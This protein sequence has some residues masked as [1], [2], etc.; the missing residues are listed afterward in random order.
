MLVLCIFRIL[1]SIMHYL[2]Q[3]NFMCMIGV[4][5]GEKDRIP[6]G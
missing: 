3:M 1:Q 5:K 2:Q 6:V 4:E